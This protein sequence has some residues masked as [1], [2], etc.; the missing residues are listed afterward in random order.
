MMLRFIL[1]LGALCLCEG[2]MVALGPQGLNRTILPPPTAS[3]Y[4]SIKNATVCQQLYVPLGGI[5]ISQIGVHGYGAQ[6][7][8]SLVGSIYNSHRLV[9]VAHGSSTFQTQHFLTL[10][11]QV[12]VPEGP[13]YVCLSSPNTTYDFKVAKEDK[14][15]RWTVMHG[16]QDVGDLPVNITL[17]ASPSLTTISLYFVG[18]S[19]TLF[20]FPEV[21]DFED[22][23][24]CNPTG[25]S[26]VS[27][28]CPAQH[29]WLN[30]ADDDFDWSVNFGQ[31]ESRR[32][33][34]DTGPTSDHGSC[35]PNGTCPVDYGGNYIYTEASPPCGA[36]NQEPGKVAHLMTPLLAVNYGWHL[37]ISF[38]MHMWGHGD[39]QLHFDMSFDNLGSWVLDVRPHLQHDRGDQWLK[40]TL[41]LTELLWTYKKGMDSPGVFFRFRS[42]SGNVTEIS[43]EGDIALDDITINAWTLTPTATE[44][45]TA[46]P[47]PSTT[48][49]MIPTHTSTPTMVPTYTATD[50][51]T[52]TAIRKYIPIGIPDPLEIVNNRWAQVEP[53]TV[54]VGEVAALQLT[55]QWLYRSGFYEKIENVTGYAARMND[56]TAQHEEE[57]VDIKFAIWYKNCIDQAPGSGIATLNKQNIGRIQVPTEPGRY[58]LCIRHRQDWESVHPVEVVPQSANYT[59][60]GYS[61]CEQ[62]MKFNPKFCGCWYQKGNL[63]DSRNNR[64]TFTLPADMPHFLAARGDVTRLYEQ[65]CCARGVTERD[66]FPHH[67]AVPEQPV[68]ALGDAR[69][70]VCVDHPG[71]GQSGNFNDDN[72]PSVHP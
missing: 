36:T 50:T 25:C 5:T 60:F 42:I 43:F 69:W 1:A 17:D 18:E 64:P 49:T 29:G 22:W 13:A 58:M 56:A 24:R 32:G 9:T 63:A 20:D 51:S 30:P 10:P 57:Q 12:L 6:Q 8:I 53:K 23:P 35:F 48:L 66:G 15:G 65:G 27:G 2:Y 52:A 33:G 31:T 55:G 71:R 45:V 41:D 47:T 62:M 34:R 16:F 46:T 61:T 19:G 68:P 67:Q 28:P 7:P 59:L 37:S 54:I 26:I 72:L 38:W 4:T 40:Y 44:T 21:V 70:G 14:T 11:G 3:G 39:S